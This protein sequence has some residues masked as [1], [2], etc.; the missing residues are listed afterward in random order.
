[1]WAHLEGEAYAANWDLYPGRGELYTGAMP[2]GMLLT[3]YVN[4]IAAEGLASGAELLPAGSIIVKENYMPDSTFAATTVMYK[5]P[6]F[7]ADNND[8]WW[9]KQLAD[10]TVEASGRGVGCISC[11]RGVAAMDYV[12]TKQLEAT[13]H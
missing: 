9:L 3:T 6:G 10:G 5:V 1:V 7:D 2:H 4:S 8:W 11:H 12:W 13:E